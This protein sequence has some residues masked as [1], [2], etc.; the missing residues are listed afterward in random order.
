VVLVPG[1]PKITATGGLDFNDDRLIEDKLD[2]VHAK[3]PDIP[4][5][6]ADSLQARLGQAREGSTLLGLRVAFHV[7]FLRVCS[8]TRKLRY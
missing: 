5:G 6:A 7:F 1:G 8:R 3:H 4:Q 2:R